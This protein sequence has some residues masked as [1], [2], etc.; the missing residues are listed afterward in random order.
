MEDEEVLNLNQDELISLVQD[1]RKR[2]RNMVKV[3]SNYGQISNDDL[4][5]ILDKLIP[6]EFK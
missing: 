6:E 2:F 3:M 1:Y 4:I 5:G